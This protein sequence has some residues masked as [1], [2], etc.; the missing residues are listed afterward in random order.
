MQL[1]TKQDFQA[2]MHLFLDPLK[3]YYSAGGARLH[4]GETGVTYGQAAIELEAFSRPLWALVPFWV[5][6]GSDPEFE[7]IYRRGLAAGSDPENPEYWGECK[8]YDQCFVEMAA[9]ACGLLNAPEKLW[10][11]LSGAEKQNLARW[12]DQ[13]N[14]HQIPECNWQFFMILVNLALK[15]CGMPY[16]P[17]NM[18]RGLARIDSYYSGD[19]WSTDGASP[20]KDYYIPW[21]IQY[22]GVLYSKFAA[23]TDPE[24]AAL[25]RSRAEL[26]AQ[27]FIYWFDENGAALPYGRSLTYRFAQNCFWAACVW[28][29]LEPFPLGVMKGLI[30]RNFNWWLDQ[31]MFDRDGILTIGYCYPQMY[32]AER[33]NAPG[34]PYWGMKSFILLALPDSHPF[35]SAEAEPMP[36]LDAL[37][38]MPHA[39]MLV[40]R[41]KGRVTA[42][43]AG[44]NEGHGHGQFPEKYAKFAYDTRFGF[45][46]SRSREVIYQAAPDSMLAFVIDDN[47]FVRKVSLSHEIRA[48]RVVSKWS[49]FPGITVTTTVLP[50]A[51]GHIRRHEIESAYPCEAYDCGFAVPNFAPGYV[52]STAGGAATARNAAVSCTVSGSGEGTVIK[53]DPNVSL[54]STNVCIPAV[55]YAIPEGRTVLE[56]EIK[57]QA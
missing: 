37:K 36:A 33:Y 24:R 25:Y 29:G 48:D 56:T 15:K 46:A 34:S 55:R 6:G 8:D 44:V 23:D 52:E 16:D 9:I 2:L 41:T 57:A 7:D 13:I 11:P 38:P 35:W 53:C 3:P 5:G 20:Q 32:M 10:D 1:S 14:H 21:A 43:A 45:C 17:E 27:Q 54:Y 40:A 28:A 12:L 47:V 19:G 4:L 18:A 39:N 22:Y 31:K 42:Y 26:F 49:P 50:T 30:V 51:D